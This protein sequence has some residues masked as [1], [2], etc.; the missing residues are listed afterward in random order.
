MEPFGK[1]LPVLRQIAYRLALE[2]HALGDRSRAIAPAEKAFKWCREWNDQPGSIKSAILLL[3]IYGDPAFAD[4]SVERQQHWFN[5][6]Q[7]L[8]DATFFR[9]DRACAY[10]ELGLAVDSLNSEDGN[11]Q[12]RGVEMLQKS[13][14]LYRSIPFVESRQSCE[15]LQRCL[16]E[17]YDGAR[18]P[19]GEENEMVIENSNAS[20]DSV[21]DE[22]MEYVTKPL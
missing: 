16:D 22:L 3:R 6:L 8:A 18:P 10:W 1:R 7:Q 9:L 4:C 19:H 21:Y 12:G 17:K 15:A 2:R 14:N 13:Y 5:E 20:I 11:L